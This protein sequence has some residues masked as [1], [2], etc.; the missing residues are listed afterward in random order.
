VLAIRGLLRGVARRRILE[1][2]RLRHAE[3]AE[4]VE[5]AAPDQVL[6][7]LRLEG[8]SA[9]GGAG[10]RRDAQAVV[11][12]ARILALEQVDHREDHRLGRVELVAQRPDAEERAQ[13]GQQLDTLERLVEE[14]VGAGVEPPHLALD[15]GERGEQEDGHEA[16][17]A[18]R[19]DPP[20]D[21]EAVDLRHHQVEQHG[22][23]R[24]AGDRVERLGAVS[25]ELH[26][27]ALLLEDRAEQ[28]E[29]LGLVVD[30]EDAG[31]L[32]HGRSLA[33]ARSMTAKRI[34][35]SIG[36]AT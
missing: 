1:K 7:R 24:P 23:R 19:L 33:Q 9:R 15:V 35:A 16:G 6:G 13:P 11:A 18:P 14:V 22:V 36:L 29:V 26:R 17:R 25:R 30:G 12:G 10:Q 2:D 34:G 4:V 28:L 8:E 31:L 32:P 5:Q 21:L 27:E 3:L 20:A